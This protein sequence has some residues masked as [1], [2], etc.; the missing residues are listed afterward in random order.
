[1]DSPAARLRGHELQ[2]TGT[3]QTEG[4]KGQKGRKG[5]QRHHK[6]PLSDLPDLSGGTPEKSSG[7]TCHRWMARPSDA[8]FGGAG[9]LASTA[10]ATA[11]SHFFRSALA[12]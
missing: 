10:S 3:N 9:T 5:A 12:F 11:F 4:Q 2:P 8:G 6:A 7:L 1:M